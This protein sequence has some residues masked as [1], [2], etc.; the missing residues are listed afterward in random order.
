MTAKCSVPVNRADQEAILCPVDGLGSM[1]AW[2]L[3]GGGMIE[4]EDHRLV[5]PGTR[6][7]PVKETVYGTI[8]VIRDPFGCRSGEMVSNRM[9]HSC[10]S[11][12]VGDSSPGESVP[13]AK[14]IKTE[15]GPKA[16]LAGQNPMLASMLAK[17]PRPVASVPTSIANAIVS[18][19]PQDRLPKNLEKKLLPTPAPPS[20]SAGSQNGGQSGAQ[21]ATSN[22]ST[23]AATVGNAHSLMVMTMSSHCK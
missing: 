12:Q 5:G 7:S 17:T 10:L 18:Q 19:I 23:S 15:A 22:P 9:F 14:R 11:Y 1:D 16:H 13:A 21:A 20:S 4:H 3:D 2:I 8:A 6:S